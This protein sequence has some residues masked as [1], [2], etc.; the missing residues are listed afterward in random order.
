M[1]QSQNLL[2]TYFRHMTIFEYTIAVFLD[3]SKAFGTID[4]TLL[5]K[6]IEHHGIRGLAL[7]WFESYLSNRE[8]IVQC[9]TATAFKMPITCGVPQGSVL[10]PLLFLVL[11]CSVL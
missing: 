5:L 3:L 7:N 10:G 2:L 4:H 1:T 11:Y 9:N 8:K 6:K